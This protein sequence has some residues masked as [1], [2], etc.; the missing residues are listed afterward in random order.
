MARIRTIKPV[1][2]RHEKLQELEVNHPELRPMLTFCCLW[3]QCDRAGRFEWRVRQLKL[4]ILPFIDY[5]LG[6]AMD[7]LE[8]HGF[9]QR[10]EVDGKVYGCVPSWLEHQFPNSRERES[11][12][13][14]P[15]EVKTA[16]DAAG[17]AQEYS[18]IVPE[19]ADAHCGTVP[20]SAGANSGTAPESWERERKKGKESDFNPAEAAKALAVERGWSGLRVIEQIRL[21]IVAVQ[22]QYSDRR[23]QEIADWLLQRT[24]DYD[25][26]AKVKAGFRMGWE[27]FF[28]EAHYNDRA[29]EWECRS[30]AEAGERRGPPA[31][32]ATEDAMAL[33]RERQR[34]LEEFLARRQP[35]AQQEA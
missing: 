10:Y 17:T 18:G 2:A 6:G 12:T 35:G 24:H 29:E 21:A 3:M 31:G 9:V 15:P 26:C 28:G 34:K 27:K 5:D 25:R 8:E 16:Q 7:L 33:I 19:Y 23:T 14:P 11:K 1:F 20:E 30:G 32:G 4:D 13:P 22:T